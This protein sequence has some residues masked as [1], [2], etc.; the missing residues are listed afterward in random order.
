MRV[1]ISGSR[2]ITRLSL[3]LF[4]VRK[5]QIVSGITITELVSGHAEGVDRLGERYAADRGI[6][7]KVFET[8]WER[9]G[10]SVGPRRNQE[11]VEYAEALI[12]IWDG[13]SRGT[14]DIIFKAKRRGLKVY[15]KR[16]E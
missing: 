2:N 7:I 8:Q 6:R 4:A 11:M 16:V 9:S 10:R 14:L 3:V 1:I 12:V 15:V 5:A 13:V